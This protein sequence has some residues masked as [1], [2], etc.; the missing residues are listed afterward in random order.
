M[1]KAFSYIVSLVALAACTPGAITNS[2]YKTTPA[3]PTYRNARLTLAGKTVERK[4]DNSASEDEYIC[5]PGFKRRDKN[6]LH[7][8][9]QDKPQTKTRPQRPELETPGDF[10]KKNST[11]KTTRP[12]IK[13]G[14][15]SQVATGQPETVDLNEETDSTSDAS[16]ESTNSADSQNLPPIAGH[17]DKN[18]SSQTPKSSDESIAGASSEKKKLRPLGKEFLIAGPVVQVNKT[19]ITADRILD[20]LHPHISRLPATLPIKSFR[21]RIA[22]MLQQELRFQVQQELILQDAKRFMQDHL[23]QQIKFQVENFKRELIANADGSLEKLRQQCISEGTTLN[24]VLERRRKNLTVSFYLRSKFEPL[25]KVNRR[26]MW[27][28]YKAHPDEFSSQKE[29][30]MQIIAFPSAAYAPKIKESMHDKLPEEQLAQAKKIAHTRAKR[31]LAELKSG[32][33]FEAIVKKYSKGL[34]AK[35]RGIWPMMK[36]GNKIE[37]NVEK[38]AFSQAQGQVSGIIEEPTGYYIVK[39]YK[40]KPAVIVPFEKSQ[41]DIEKKIKTAQFAKMRLD[42][43]QE[44]HKKAIIS[45]PKEFYQVA[46]QKAER[47]Y[48]KQ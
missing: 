9:L 19:H 27:K 31:A 10:A 13:A 2:D 28:Y 4:T 21:K 44:I 39:T 26:L 11:S 20:I 3:D 29:I 42:Y 45:A 22:E 16:N 12:K 30:Q 5:L 33:E 25:I 41:F 17:Q 1:K 46:M 37:Q 38:I 24:A 23:K 34:K 14:T 36:A 43:L 15:D 7:N 47:K 48:R 8:D 35:N 32:A 18:N 40:I 6:S